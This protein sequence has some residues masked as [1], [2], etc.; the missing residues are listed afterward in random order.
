MCLVSYVACLWHSW[1]SLSVFCVVVVFVFVMCLKG[2]PRMPETGNIGH[3]THNKYKNNNHTENWKGPPRI[4]YVSCVLCC[5][6]LAFLVVP[7][8]FLCGCC[9]CICYVSCVLCNNHTENWKGPPRMPETGNIGHKTH[10]KYKN[11]NHTE[12]WKGPPRMPETGNIGHKTHNKYKNNTEN[13]KGPPRMPETGNIVLGG[14]FRFSVLFLYLLC[15]LCPMLPVSGILGGP[16][17][18]SVLFLYLLCVL[19]PML[20]VSGILGGP[21]QFSVWLLFLHR[22]LKGATKNARDRQHRTQD[23]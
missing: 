3:K 10:S 5:L 1:W 4:C 18:F 22:K 21:F 8:S 14:P 2:S 23:T 12:N 7:F 11:N 16:F 13:W 9:F 15:V 19:C 6:S 20:P 17:Q